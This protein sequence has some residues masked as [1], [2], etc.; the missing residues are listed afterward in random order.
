[1]EAYL[2]Q[3]SQSSIALCIFRSR[4][5]PAG[6]GDLILGGLSDEESVR[7]EEEV[8]VCVCGKSYQNALPVGAFSRIDND[9]SV[10]LLLL[11]VK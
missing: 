7:E 6:V 8:C 9:Y 3:I 2:W 1:M 4:S 11:S 5:Y 10:T